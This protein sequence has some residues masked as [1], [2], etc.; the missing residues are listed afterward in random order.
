M[1]NDILGKLYWKN[2]PYSDVSVE[3]DNKHYNEN[4]YVEYSPIISGVE[5]TT[6]FTQKLMRKWRIQGSY[7][8]EKDIFQLG[9]DYTSDTYLPYVKIHTPIR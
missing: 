4:G 1:A 9:T 8:L 5:E 2:L 7:A 3:S 6:G